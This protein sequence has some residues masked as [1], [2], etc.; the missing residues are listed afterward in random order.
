MRLIY[1]II[2]FILITTTSHS[3]EISKPDFKNN[4]A[5][6]KPINPAE[7]VINILPFLI[8]FL[9]GTYLK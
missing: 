8:I 2:S 5:K 9:D 4:L 1:I 7:P 6:E 3:Q